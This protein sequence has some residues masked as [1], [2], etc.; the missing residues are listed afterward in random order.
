MPSTK[1]TTT[2]TRPASSPFIRFP[3]ELVDI[4]FTLAAKASRHTCL[5]LCLVSSSARQIALP[6]LFRTIVVTDDHG[7]KFDKHLVDPE[8]KLIKTNISAPSLVQNFWM[9]L[10]GNAYPVW[11]VFQSC[12]NVI[13]MAVDISSFY[14]LVYSTSSVTIT[15]EPRM[16][17]GPALDHNRN[18]HLTLLEP[19]Y[20]LDDAIELF[21]PDVSLRSPLYDRITHIRLETD[22]DEGMLYQLGHFTRLSH[23]CISYNRSVHQIAQDLVDFLTRGSLQMLVVACVRKPRQREKLQDW[24][25][26]KRQ[27]EKKVFFVEIPAKDI[28]ARWEEEMRGGETPSIW[29]RALNYTAQWEAKDMADKVRI[30]FDAM[31]VIMDLFYFCLFSLGITIDER[32][33]CHAASVEPPCSLTVSSCHLRTTV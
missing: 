19:S 14:R 25:R 13:H 17:S 4:I 18:L 11:E 20:F 7:P 24:V 21:H 23:L 16:V 22:A 1:A 6:Y 10:D 15:G 29:D 32:P 28:R 30:I 5:D 27:T 31:M 2:V 8:Y 12:H 26:E 9:S 33:R 3:V